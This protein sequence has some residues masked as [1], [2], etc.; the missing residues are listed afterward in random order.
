MARLE[1]CY[2]QI[3]E[4]IS[5]PLK[6]RSSWISRRSVAQGGG[7]CSYKQLSGPQWN[8]AIVVDRRSARMIFYRSVRLLREIGHHVLS[9]LASRSDATRRVFYREAGRMQES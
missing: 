5:D 1:Y 6:R 2:R 8:S 4:E 3:F 7:A 9:V